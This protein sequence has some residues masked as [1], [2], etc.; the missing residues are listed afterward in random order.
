M[1]IIRS[2]GKIHNDRNSNGIRMV[3]GRYCNI[4]TTLTL[5]M[6]T[7]QFGGLGVFRNSPLAILL[8]S[9]GS[10]G[11]QSGPAPAPATPAWWYKR[12]GKHK[13]RVYVSE[14]EKDN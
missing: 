10:I 6:K 12:L 8:L 7:L 3:K 1:T 13:Y 14:F 2:T 11:S 9:T 4:H 5:A